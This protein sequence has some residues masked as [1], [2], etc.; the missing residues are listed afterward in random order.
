MTIAQLFVTNKMSRLEKISMDV[1]REI[2]Q[3]LTFDVPNKFWATRG[4]GWDGKVRFFNRPGNTFAT[5]LLPIIADILSELRVQYKTIDMRSD[6]IDT[7]KINLN[8]I[9]LIDK[10]LR[11]YQY[12]SVEAL[13]TYRAA[14]IP[15]VR[16]VVNV[17]TNGGKTIIAEAVV[18]AIYSKLTKGKKLLFITHSKE[19]AH[20][21]V[22]RFKSDLG[23]EPGYI[24][25]GRWEEKPVI[26]ALIP[27]LYANR[28]LTASEKENLRNYEAGKVK[29]RPRSPKKAPEFNRLMEDTIAVIADEVHHASSDSWYK[30]MNKMKNASIRIGL[31]G[32]VGK[33]DIKKHKLF[34]VTG[35]VI[36]KI[37]NSYLIE[38]G[39]S[40][41]PIVYFVKYDDRR[42]LEGLYYQDAYAEGIVNN[43]ARNEAILQI[44]AD[45]RY[46]RDSNILILVERI[47]HG[48]ILEQMIKDLDV[49]NV[50]FTHGGR[51]TVFRNWVLDSVRKDTTQILISTAILDEGVD[52]SNINSIV[53]ARGMKADRKILQGIGRGLRKKEDGSELTF[54][55]FLD[56]NNK[57]LSRHTSERFAVLEAEGF[58]IYKLE[59]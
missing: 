26:V 30:M 59:L 33:D 13:L 55:D 15:F 39:H 43:P 54:Y 3:R 40:A 9:S 29:K 38:Q 4:G 36:S 35:P 2:S 46:E 8:K 51:E 5:G 37:S 22:L 6:I 18:Q 57:Y 21:T 50:M 47:E 34:S 20:Q 45:E 49:G 31:T 27:T 41:K 42:D 24:G 10:E 23:I 17:A 12:E 52:V 44:V 16:G 48:E 1:E 53:Y 25:D 19:I 11:D 56:L 28:P 32:T 7:E 58:E 14:G